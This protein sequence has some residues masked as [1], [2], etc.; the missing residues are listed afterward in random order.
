MGSLALTVP[1][2]GSVY[3]NDIRVKVTEAW[4]FGSKFKVEVTN[5]AE[6]WLHRYSV[7]EESL[8]WLDNGD[9]IAEIPPA[10]LQAGPDST[11][12]QV[13]LVIDAPDEVMVLREHL[14]HNYSTREGYYHISR[15]AKQKIRGIFTGRVEMKDIAEM[16][17]KAAR[18]THPKGNRRFENLLFE[19]KGKVVMDIHLWD[20]VS[21]TEAQQPAGDV[22]TALYDD[23]PACE[24][25]GCAKCEDGQI[26]IGNAQVKEQRT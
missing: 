10:S 5:K 4:D 12:H 17:H 6:S 11:S 24:G 26:R 22:S 23:C 18:V 14:Y 21:V 13:K 25:E 9:V 8:T 3:L 2:G 16:V 15:P 20:E 7:G 19:V 1:V